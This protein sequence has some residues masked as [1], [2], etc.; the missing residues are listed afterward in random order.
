M[1]LKCFPNLS[2]QPDALPDAEVANQPGQPESDHELRLQ[3][4][5][6]VNLGWGCNLL[7][8]LG[9]ICFS[10]VY[11]NSLKGIVHHR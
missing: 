11:G 8:C 3:T 10:V 2:S 9:N 5:R 4:A 6:L 1:L 7:D